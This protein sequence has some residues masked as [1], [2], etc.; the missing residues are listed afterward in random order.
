MRF[1]YPLLATAVTGLAATPLASHPHVFVDTDLALEV[2]A[3]GLVTAV[4]VTWTYD[5]FETLLVLDE[6]GLAGAYDTGLSAADAA[7]PERL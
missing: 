4:A 2:D 7:D 5:E 3:A 6:W 1:L